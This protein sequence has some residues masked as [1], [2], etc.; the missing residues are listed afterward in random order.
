MASTHKIVNQ[1]PEEIDELWQMAEDQI[2]EGG[3]KYPGMTYEEGIDAV[4]RWIFDDGDHPL[5]D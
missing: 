3:S 1:N 4:L 2:S 5:K